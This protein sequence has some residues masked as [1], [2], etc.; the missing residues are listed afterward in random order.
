[1]LAQSL[2]STLSALYTARAPSL[3]LPAF[4]APVLRVFPSY[5]PGQLLTKAPSYAAPAPPYSSKD[6]LPATGHTLVAGQP[7]PGL[8]S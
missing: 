2:A 8:P 6:T 3:V 5:R 4:R 1:M 7:L